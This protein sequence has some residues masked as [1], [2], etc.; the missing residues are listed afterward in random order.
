[1]RLSMQCDSGDTRARSEEMDTTTQQIHQAT[2]QY[3][4][5][6]TREHLGQHVCEVV[7]GGYLLHD[8]ISGSLT[9]TND[10]LT[11]HDVTS[12]LARR[13][14]L[15]QRQHILGIAVARRRQILRQT[16]GQTKPELH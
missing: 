11:P 2:A 8:D 14:V 9:L 16:L 10:E 6:I 13:V 7:G 3:L 5:R 15:H 12:V 4:E 1:M